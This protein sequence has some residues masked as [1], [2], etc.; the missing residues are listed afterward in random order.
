MVTFLE[1]AA[2]CCTNREIVLGGAHQKE[3]VFGAQALHEGI[4]V[5]S[6][7]ELAYAG[8]RGD[9]QPLIALLGYSRGVP[10]GRK[11]LFGAHAREMRGE[12]IV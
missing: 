7:F 9:E 4:N 3:I 10:G 8:P 12:R 1:N 5:C 11:F 2:T 6:E